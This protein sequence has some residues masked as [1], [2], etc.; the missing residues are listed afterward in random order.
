MI[1]SVSR[2]SD[3]PAFHMEW[4]STVLA[5]G[6]VE[7]VNPFR[8]AQKRIVQLGRDDVDAFIFWTRQPKPLLPVLNKLD[9]S[10]IPACVMVTLNAYPPVLE[11]GAPAL[12]EALAAMA[13]LA[14]TI[15]RDRVIWRYDPLIFSADSDAEF[16]RRHF[17]NLAEQVTSHAFRVVVSLYDPY[18]KAAARLRRAG[19]TLWPAEQTE[20]ALPGLLGALAETASGC[21]LAI[22][23]CAETDA[24]TRWGIPAGKC[25]DD[26]W[27]N[28]RFGLQLKYEKDTSQ[29]P[30]CR[31]QRSVDIG[32]YN[33]CRFHCR[34][35]YAW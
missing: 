20:A 16:H 23:S 34:Y 11:P 19:V 26:N 9:R 32:S 18:R 1:V 4:F 28:E 35:C 12:A 24:W 15:G 8:P 33:T 25:V 27:L 29:R 3:V 30:A 17:R 6:Y 14:A 21:G 31:C 10:G 5:R 22:Q 2:R 13:E 7:T